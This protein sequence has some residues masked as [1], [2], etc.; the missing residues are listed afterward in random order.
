MDLELAGKAIVVTGGA[1]GIGR[2]CAEAFA[3]EGARVAIMDCD[4]D[5]LAI[6]ERA[7]ADLGAE[8]LAL[9]V[10]VTKAAEVDAVH[11]M[12][13]DTF[14]SV[15]VAFNNAGVISGMSPIADL[16]EDDWDRVISVNLKG[17][18]LC[19]RA[20]VRHMQQ[21][22]EGVIIANASN[23][24]FVGV[25]GAVP[26][27]A[28]KHGIIGIMRSVALEVAADGI[29]VNCIAPGPINGATGKSLPKN[30]DGKITN[31]FPNAMIRQGLPIGRIGE[32]S[33][34]ADAVLWLASP[35]SSFVMGETLVA[36][37]GFLAQ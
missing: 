37:G 13:A 7:I 27:V 32:A 36:D 5:Q 3:R 29:R 17:I 28:A 19:I 26:Y 20:Q 12:V 8:V 30:K 6:A 16:D 11:D 4:A 33:E 18:F 25:P 9:E 2:A 21:R 22:G 34:I 1:S 24:A 10:D 15:D 23:T 14:G 31:P 35:R